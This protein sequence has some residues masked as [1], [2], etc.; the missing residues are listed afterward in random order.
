MFKTNFKEPPLGCFVVD[1]FDIFTPWKRASETHPLG[2]HGLK[3]WA[4]KLTVVL[5]MEQ[6]LQL[7]LRLVIYPIV[8]RVFYIQGGAV[9]FHQQ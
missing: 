6:I 3:V 2:Y 1:P 5:L 7:M 4:A 8:W 9:F